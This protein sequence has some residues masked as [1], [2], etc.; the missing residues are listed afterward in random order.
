M[1]ADLTELPPERRGPS[2]LT[3]LLG[4]SALIL[5]AMT[6]VAALFSIGRLLD[7]RL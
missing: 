5:V 2:K 3:A 7:S 4:Y 1:P 6:V